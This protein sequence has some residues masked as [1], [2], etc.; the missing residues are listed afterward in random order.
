VKDITKVAV[1]D[2]LELGVLF[3]DLQAKAGDEMHFFITVMKGGAEIERSPWRGHI[4]VTVPTENFEA[5][6]WY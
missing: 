4:S 1:R 2:I 3:T 5:M 6:M